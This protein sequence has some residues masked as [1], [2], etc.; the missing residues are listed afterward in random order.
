M[1]PFSSIAEVVRYISETNTHRNFLNY[2]TISGEWKSTSVSEFMEELENLTLGLREIGVVKGSPVGILAGSST[3]WTL[4]DF[5]IMLAGGITVPLFGN[6]S[7]ENFGFEIEQTGLKYIFVAGDE[8]WQMLA[9]HRDSFT[10]VINMLDED[11]HDPSIKYSD[12]VKKGREVK[13]NQPDLFK[14]MLN[15]IKPDDLATIVYTSGSTGLPKGAMLTHRNAVS[16]VH[17]N[18]F[19]RSH[20]KDVYLSVLPLAHIFA[21][22]INFLMMVWGVPIYYLRDIKTIGD[23][24]KNLQP[25]ILVLVPRIIEKIYDKIITKIRRSSFVKKTI[26]EWAVNVANREDDFYTA[27][28]LPIADKLVYSHLREALGG[29]IE[30]V[31]SGGAPLNPQLGRFFNHIGVPMLEGWGLTEAATVTCNRLE[32]NKIGSVGIPFDSIEIKIDEKGEILVKGP[33]VMKGYYKNEEATK[34]AFTPEGLL[35]TGDKGKIDADGYLTI[36]GRIKE[37]YKTSTGEYIAPVPIEQELCKAPLIDMAVVVADG[38]KFASCLLFPDFEVL[39]N[40][41]RDQSKEQVSDAEFLDSSFIKEEMDRLFTGLNQHLNHWE[42]I[43]GYKFV[44][45]APSVE[46]GELTPT[47]KMKRENVL[48]KYRQ[49][50]DKIYVE[51]TI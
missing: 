14:K 23:V 37:L 29:K 49:L 10:T 25:T 39:K 47:M 44:P 31:I 40:L 5:A 16:L 8:Q 50:I 28:M 41:K 46:G 22:S 12:L 6:I 45:N 51:E 9:H 1:K 34:Q 33:L 36:E 32:K 24:C 35:R 3:R 15:E 4:S 20:D 21:R 38:R 7:D 19:H 30:L 18:P 2:Q 17:L 27:C 11:C 43:R 26:G 42:Q 48:K 13:K